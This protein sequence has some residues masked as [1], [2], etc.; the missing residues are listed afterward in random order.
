MESGSLGKVLEIFIAWPHF[1]VTLIPDSGL[2]VTSQLTAPV[3]M[4]SPTKQNVSP[5]TVRQNV[6]S[7]FKVILIRS[8][9]NN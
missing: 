2:N 8:Q 4:T 1:L 3:A 9:E 5:E 7:F 6:S